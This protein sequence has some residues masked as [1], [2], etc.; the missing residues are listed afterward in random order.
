MCLSVYSIYVHVHVDAHTYSIVL[1]FLPPPR[2]NLQS[3]MH[4]EDSVLMLSQDRV[5]SLPLMDSSDSES[6]S[7]EAIT[8]RQ[9]GTMSVLFV[10]ACLYMYMY[11][12]YF[13]GENFANAVPKEAETMY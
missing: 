11:L 6:G 13:V 12:I 5:L 1:S 2:S 4:Q 8:L 7:V 3:E 10:F 9:N